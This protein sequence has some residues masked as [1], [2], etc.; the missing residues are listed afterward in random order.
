MV[1]L[2]GDPASI[3]ELLGRP[4]QEYDPEGSSLR[5]VPTP[6][7]QAGWDVSPSAQEIAKGEFSQT[8]YSKAVRQCFDAES[9]PFE[10]RDKRAHEKVQRLVKA[11]GDWLKMLDSQEEQQAAVLAAY[12][13]LLDATHTQEHKAA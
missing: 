7:E 3:P 10:E 11:K 1:A 4:E 13:F 8:V 6:D 5:L 12:S 2:N 9:Q